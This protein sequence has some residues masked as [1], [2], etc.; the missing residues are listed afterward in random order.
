MLLKY[1]QW[2]E[3]CVLAKSKAA[4][5]V[6]SKEIGL[7]V[8]TEKTTYMVMTRGQRGGLVTS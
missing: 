8:N 2:P 5:L 7:E 3:A 1:I 4:S 6:Y